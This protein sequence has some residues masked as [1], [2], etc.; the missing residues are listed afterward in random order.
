M[1]SSLVYGS[2]IF[3]NKDTIFEVNNLLETGHGQ[4]IKVEE[5]QGV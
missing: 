2:V 4:N 1:T 5:N 3:R